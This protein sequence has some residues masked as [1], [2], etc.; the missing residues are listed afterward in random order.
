MQAQL[1]LQGTD[2][3]SQVWALGNLIELYLLAPTIPG[4][5]SRGPDWPALAEAHTQRLL[6]ACPNGAFELFSTRRQVK[7]YTDWYARLAHP[8]RP[9]DAQVLAAAARIVDLLPAEVVT[10]WNYATG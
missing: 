6:A 2:S 7:R 9:W 3:Q 4:V 8:D 5:A 10:H 1:D